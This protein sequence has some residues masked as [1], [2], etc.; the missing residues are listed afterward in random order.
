MESCPVSLGFSCG[1]TSSNNIKMD[2]YHY[3]LA[4]KKAPAKWDDLNFYFDQTATVLN[5]KKFSGFAQYSRAVAK[6]SH[7]AGAKKAQRLGYG[8]RLIDV[9]T[10][11]A[12]I[13]RIRRSK[14]FRTG[15][16]M[17]DA[18]RWRTTLADSEQQPVSTPHC[19]THWTLSW[20]VFHGDTLVAY[21]VLTR[22]GNFLRMG[23]IMG[24]GDA[25]R[26][27]VMKLLMFDIVKWLY[28]DPSTFL[29]GIESFMYGA[30]EHGAEGL[31]A[32]KRRLR[33]DPVL[34]DMATLRA[35]N[36][37]LDF[38]AATYLDLNPDV[39]KAGVD[40]HAHYMIWGHSEG[41]R[42]R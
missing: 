14:L 23:D 22:C 12:S 10:L 33:F 30:L 28:Q 26:D 27:G 4:C 16:L 7:G 5:L 40:A 8:T 36:L 32:W 41:R 1:D 9:E 19:D 6:K 24:H 2:A 18:L 37:P 34:I 29:R 42:H 21:A 13:D 3:L 17:P 11:K 15:G 31:P 38:D 25:L 20:G 39:K 35:E